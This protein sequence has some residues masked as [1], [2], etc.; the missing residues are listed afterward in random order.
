[1]QGLFSSGIMALDP[2]EDKRVWSTAFL[3]PF[4]YTVFPVTFIVLLLYLGRNQ[5][6]HLWHRRREREFSF[7][8]KMD[9]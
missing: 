7:S 5:I 9:V 6:S 3:V 2:Q 1:M 8:E 4:V